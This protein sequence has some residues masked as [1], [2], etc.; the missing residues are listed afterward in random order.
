MKCELW[1]N[2]HNCCLVGKKKTTDCIFFFP[3][4]SV[5]SQFHDPLS[6]KNLNVRFQKNTPQKSLEVNKQEIFYPTSV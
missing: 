1:A 6:L 4:M 5:L 3:L 2:V